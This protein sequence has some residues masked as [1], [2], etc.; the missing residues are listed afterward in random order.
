MNI[1]ISAHP[2]LQYPK[3]SKTSLKKRDIKSKMLCKIFRARYLDSA[4]AGNLHNLKRTNNL[5]YEPSS[6]LTG[7]CV[8]TV[9]VPLRLGDT[10]GLVWGVAGAVKLSLV[11]GLEISTL[12]P[13]RDGGADP[14]NHIKLFKSNRS[15]FI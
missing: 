3:K 8:E 5:G 4:T 1:S 12:E 6:S 10:G 14:K 2:R 11:P 13:D 15:I 7:R 9:T